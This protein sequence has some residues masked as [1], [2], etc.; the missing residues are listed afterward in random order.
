[1]NTDDPKLL[2]QLKDNRRL[3]LGGSLVCGAVGLVPLPI[4][5]DLAIDGLRRA[6]LVRL[7]ARRGVK[8]GYGTARHLQGESGGFARLGAS[9]AAAVGVRSL[10]RVTRTLLLLLRFEE[11]ARTYMLGTYFDYYLL[12]YHRGEAI[13]TE[14]AELVGRAAG[15]AYSGAHLDVLVALFRRAAGEIWR[16]GSALPGQLWGMAAALLSGDD[17]ELAEEKEQSDGVFGRLLGLLE[18]QLEQ[19]GRATVLALLS[20]YD[21]A[22]SLSGGQGEVLRSGR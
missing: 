4:L 21:D 14:Q 9:S 3:L 2:E 22:W 1:M 19:T 17:E 10:T 11:M 18:Q 5:P 15:E 20:G 12:R 7:A 13:S 8:L 6:L 16:V